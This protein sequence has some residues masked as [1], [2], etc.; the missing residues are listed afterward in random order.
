MGSIQYH[1]SST[2]GSLYI[3]ASNQALQGIYFQQQE[4]P[5]SRT[6]MSDTPASRIII[7]TMKQLEEYFSGN[8]KQFDLDVTFQGTDFQR[9]VW[10]QLSK[11]PFG[12]TVSYRDIAK[13]IKNPKAVRAVGNANGKNPFSIIVPC[14]RVIAADGS[15]G[16]YGGGIAVKEKLLALELS[17]Y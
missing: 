17:K 3:V 1:M 9:K 7:K 14:H 12:T 8:R 5:L 10:M 2:I 11:I 15:I 16:G 4:M 13:R 6:L